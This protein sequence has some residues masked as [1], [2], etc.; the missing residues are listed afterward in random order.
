MT[1]VQT[2]AL[3]ISFKV[4]PWTL[5]SKYMWMSIVAVA[6]I[7]I[8]SVYFIMPFSPKGIPGHKEFTWNLVNYSPIL[9]GG[10]LIILWVWWNMSAKKWFTGPRSNINS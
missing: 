7:A 3:P 6:E 5:G 10:A 4:G 9:T 2:C 1:G 8:I